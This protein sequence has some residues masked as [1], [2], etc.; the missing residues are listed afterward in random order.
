ME[1]KNKYSKDL[2][3]NRR[4]R[5]QTNQLKVANQYGKMTN[6]EKEPNKMARLLFTQNNHKIQF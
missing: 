6:S 1:Q 2:K 4:Q 5:S 3:K